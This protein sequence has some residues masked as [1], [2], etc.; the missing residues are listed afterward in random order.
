[1]THRAHVQVRLRPKRRAEPALRSATGLEPWTQGRDAGNGASEWLF[2][3]AAPL[4][5]TAQ[6][7]IARS[8]QRALERTLTEN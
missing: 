8:V 1:M 5:C 7:G 6:Q 4:L 3:P 2:V